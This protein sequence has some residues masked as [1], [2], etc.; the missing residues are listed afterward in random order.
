MK[1]YRLNQIA[2][3]VL[4]ALLLFFGAKTIVNIAFEE[5][6]PEKP[7]FEVATTEPGAKPAGEV[8]PAG[9]DI[10][11]RLAKADVGRGADVA[12]KCQLCHNIDKGG[13]NVIGPNLYGVIGRDVASQEGF[14]YS[15]ELKA[16]GGKWD[17]ASIDAMIT[18]PGAYVPGTKM[19]LFPGLPD[20]QQRADVLIFLRTKN[21]NPPP[22]PEAAAGDAAAPAP[23]AETAAPSAGTAAPSAETPAS[24]A[25]TPAPAEDAAPD[26]PSATAPGMVVPE[27][28]PS[29]TAGPSEEPNREPESG[30]APPQ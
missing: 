3:A 4:G 12:K 25:E 16:K 20:A 14:D 10:A 9:S 8:K 18:N 23:A 21:D 15:P 19:A 17:Y 1:Y 26:Q 7:G 22:L 6:E 28:A 30:E 24:S 2:M 27:A 29:A 13:P 5:P 11:V